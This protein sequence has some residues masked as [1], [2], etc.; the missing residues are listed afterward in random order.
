MI[1]LDTKHLSQYVIS[2]SRLYLKYLI[3]GLN[4]I[5]IFCKIK[6]ILC[7]KFMCRHLEKSLI[8]FVA[9]YPASS[10]NLD[11]F[12]WNRHRPNCFAL[13]IHKASA[14]IFLFKILTQLVFSLAQDQVVVSKVGLQRSGRIR[15]QEVKSN[16]LLN[17]KEE[18]NSLGAKRKTRNT[19][20]N[21][22]YGL[23][24]TL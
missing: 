10:A 7:L 16:A 13:K 17:N 4:C 19:S 18:S 6:V 14:N 15:D 21:Y 20:G 5:I 8:S 9:S 23:N 2:E 1:S 22:Y 3:I 12:W 24:F 11:W